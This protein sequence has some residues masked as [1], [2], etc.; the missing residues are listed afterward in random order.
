MSSKE[1][2]VDLIHRLPDEAT[3]ADIAREI[4]FLAGIRQ[5]AQELDSGEGVM[6]EEVLKMIPQW[7]QVD[8]DSFAGSGSN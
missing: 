7:A 4:E 8:S 1:I 6:A 3:L 5:A 2:A